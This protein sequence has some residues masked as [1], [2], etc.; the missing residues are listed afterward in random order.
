MDV[1]LTKSKWQIKGCFLLIISLFIA[2]NSFGW[3]Q[4]GH[5]AVGY[6]AQLHLSKKAKKEIYKIMGNESLAMASTWMDFIKS[7]PAYNFMGAWHY[8]TIPDGET[9]AE[10]GTPE[11]GDVIET[12]ERLIKELET[13]QFTDSDE[14]MALRMLI[15]LVGD[16]H[17]PL[18]VGN[19]EDRGGNDIK[20][21]WFGQ[22]TNLHSVWDSRM[23]DGQQLS[24]TELAIS[25]NSPSDSEITSWQSD[26]I[27]VW[28]AESMSYRKELYS[29]PE[30][31]SIS[32]R[33]H[34]D[35]WATVQ[36][37]LV[38][39]GVRLAG[40]LNGIYG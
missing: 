18:H 35:N 2:S 38:Q 5:R 34:F 9:Y 10:A 8:C 32:Y 3:G 1:K 40:I 17:Q 11:E 14:L 22:S 39:A 20:L 16:I 31:M 15:H 28:A 7:D 29:L 13:R 36:K 6:I 12:I 19:G 23:I 24:Y 4:I 30:N 26:P 37:R 27:L 21:K 25:V 33:Y